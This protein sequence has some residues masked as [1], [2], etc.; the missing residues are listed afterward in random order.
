M[1]E[2]KRLSV[3]FIVGM[4]LLS[5]SPVVAQ[6]EVTTTDSSTTET[7]KATQTE[8]QT[9]D[10]NSPETSIESDTTFDKDA[11][12]TPDSAFYFLDEM[13]ERPG[14]DPE[15][16]LD[17]K[18]EK[19]AEAQEMIEAN[20]PEEAQQVLEKALEYGDILEKEVSPEIKE[21]AIESSEQIIKI[22]DDL[23][24]QSSGEG[25]NI[26]GTFD[27]NIEQ[28]GNIAV[29]AELAEK[30]NDLCMT[31]AKL[32]PLQYS[33]VCRSGDNSPRWMRESDK[34]L[35]KEQEKQADVFFDKISSCFENP[36]ECDC[37]GMGVQSFEDFCTEQSTNAVACFEGNEESCKMMDEGADPSDLLPDYLLD[38][39]Y[40]V[41][42]KFSKAKFDNFMPKECEKA[43]VTSPKECKELMFKLN[44][45]KECIDA[46]LDGSSSEDE[47]KCG[48][49]MFKS[50]SPKE[51]ID[52]GINPEDEDAPRK[53]GKLMFQKNA[54]SQCLEAGLT[55]ERRDDEAKCRQLMQGKGQFRERN[56]AQFD[57][58]CNAIADADEKMKCYEQ[59]YNNA[60]VGFS[61]EFVAREFATDQNTGEKITPEEER[62]R[63]E[64]KAKG[65]GT[66]LEYKN[67]QRIIICV[68]ENEVNQRG[69]RCQSQEQTAQLKQ[70]CQS[71]GQDAKIEDRGGCPWVVCVSISQG[72]TVQ[73]ERTIQQ[74]FN[75][76]GDF[77]PY[78][79]E[80]RMEPYET[81]KFQPPGS[82]PE[83]T[84]GKF[85]PPQQPPQGESTSPQEP[86][87]TETTT[88]ESTS[89]QESTTTPTESSSG[90]GE[91]SS[92][93]SESSSG[94]G[95]SS[96]GESTPVTGEAIFWDYY[97]K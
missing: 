26:E 81:G 51:C 44:A 23:K 13:F 1:L 69:Q 89:P 60:Q 90:E 38:V 17:Y 63:Q 24:E 41:E 55:G 54:P 10:E 66:I 22:L 34:E 35:T 82:E 9:S 53:C 5:L 75:V 86:A 95:E 96:G 12:L 20:K 16:A 42:D 80:E 70:D 94:T 30:I 45:P 65:M 52:A 11:G 88:T 3:L 62:A 74:E 6:D 46:G 68:N 28:E 18:E 83:M 48:A 58:D 72:R 59:F 92:S 87:T 61:E 79:K 71:R 7:P 39:F 50:N 43:G 84:T 15:K 57:R 14:D 4:L 93:E 36:K 47:K 77:N 85:Q 49:L 21:R 37:A 31:L 73:Q 8:T 97:F 19:I 2:V 25:W 67:G 76:Y 40:D 27:D 91:S 32:D 56:T 78:V 33:D 29:A 64:C